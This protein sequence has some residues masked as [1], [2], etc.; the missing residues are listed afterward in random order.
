MADF[1]TSITVVIPDE[2]LGVWGDSIGSA[3]ALLEECA[4]LARLLGIPP[5]LD[6]ESLEVDEAADSQGEGSERW[7]RYG[8]ETLT[9]LRLMKGCRLSL[10]SGCALVFI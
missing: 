2:D 1:L 8:V 6:A 3:V 10:A 5:G 7:Q 9:C 4:T